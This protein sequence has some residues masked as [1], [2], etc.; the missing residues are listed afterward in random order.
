MKSLSAHE[1]KKPR[2]R[3]LRKKLRIAEFREFGID[4][5]IVFCKKVISFDAALDLWIDFVESK[6]WAFA[7]GGNEGGE[8]FSGFICHPG[9]GTLDEPDTLA[10]QEWSKKQDWIKNVTQNLQDA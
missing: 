8:S 1:I 5:R 6:G 4:I 7:G 10:I 9:R 3:R 2:N